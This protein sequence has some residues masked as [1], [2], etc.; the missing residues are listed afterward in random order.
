VGRVKEIRID[1]HDIERVE[2]LLEIKEGTPIKE[3]MIAHTT[4]L[5]VTGLLAIEIDGGTNS[6]RT[7]KP[8]KTHIPVIKSSSSWFEKTRKHIG[9]LADRLAVVVSQ[10]EKLLSNENI[11]TFGKILKHTEEVTA[12]STGLVTE[13]NATIIAYRQAVEKFNR[14]LERVTE[15]FVKI[16]DQTLP[17]VKTLKKTSQNFNRLT[18]KVEKSLDR[19]DYNLQKILEPMLVNIEILAEQMGVV[20]RELDRSPSDVFF[21]SRKVKYGPGEH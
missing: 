1:P 9:T 12:K 14:N 16:S 6:A 18:L 10:T 11:E 20:L 13:A 15:A 7:L 21:K 19:G 3:D 8:D 17:A 2:I 5:G 4:M